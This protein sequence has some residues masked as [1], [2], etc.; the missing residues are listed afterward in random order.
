MTETMWTEFSSSISD[1]FVREII[2]NRDTDEVETVK[3]GNPPS[4]T[5][6]EDTRSFVRVALD[7]DGDKAIIVEDFYADRAIDIVDIGNV[8][9]AAQTCL[10]N[11]IDCFR[12]Q[13]VD[14]D[15]EVE[16]SEAHWETVF[17]WNAV[18]DLQWS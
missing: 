6:E 16:H 3:L 7:R 1:S 14:G 10:E 17:D 4:D 13:G 15:I 9:E 12:G 5:F 8:E 11:E 2:E 18:D